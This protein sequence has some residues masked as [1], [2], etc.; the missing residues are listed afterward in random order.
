MIM[1]NGGGGGSDGS[2]M[3]TPV[4]LPMHPKLLLPHAS[5]HFNRFGKSDIAHLMPHMIT[6]CPQS[7]KHIPSESLL[8]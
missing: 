4:H 2:W 1:G 6:F 7:P 3:R 8:P 5:T